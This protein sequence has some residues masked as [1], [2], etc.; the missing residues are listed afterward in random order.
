[1]N[2]YEDIFEENKS[3]VE[4]FMKVTERF[5]NEVD[6]SSLPVPLQLQLENANLKILVVT[7]MLN[8]TVMEEID[9]MKSAIVYDACTKDKE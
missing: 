3:I 1:M 5:V 8:R 2:K 7:K 4:E 9:L 6:I